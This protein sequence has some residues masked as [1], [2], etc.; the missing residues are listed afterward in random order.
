LSQPAHTIPVVAF[1][2]DY[3]SDPDGWLTEYHDPPLERAFAN[4]LG[5]SLRWNVLDRVALHYG[6]KTE[7]IKPEGYYLLDRSLA[8]LFDVFRAGPMSRWDLAEGQYG[9]TF[10]ETTYRGLY[11]VEVLWNA[12]IQFGLQDAKIDRGCT[13]A[14]YPMQ[15]RSILQDLFE[16]ALVRCAERWDKMGVWV[17]HPEP[18]TG[19]VRSSSPRD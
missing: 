5:G 8:P 12:A 4:A 18:A 3:P 14:R 15:L 6:L 1:P 11:S 2:V 13:V 7:P 19:V 10:A 16:A 17:A 9:K